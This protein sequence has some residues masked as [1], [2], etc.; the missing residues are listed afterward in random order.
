[1]ADSYSANDTYSDLPRE[2]DNRYKN[3]YY[4]VTRLNDGMGCSVWSPI[5][6]P[7]IITGARKT[8]ISGE[9]LSS[10]WFK[11]IIPHTYECA[12]VRLSV[13]KSVS[14]Q[15]R[16]RTAVTLSNIVDKLNSIDQP[17]MVDEV[18]MY[19]KFHNDHLESLTKK[20]HIKMMYGDSDSVTTHSNVE[21][22]MGTFGM[23][24]AMRKGEN[25]CMYCPNFKLYN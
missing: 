24:F 13:H 6:S 1:M 18:V 8:Y 12:V 3:E 4:F 2:L 5:L 16:V 19:H 17:E 10:V 20:L 9:F 22:E 23:S 25:P 21:N 15:T 14:R 11:S 7:F